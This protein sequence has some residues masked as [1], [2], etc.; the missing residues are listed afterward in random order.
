MQLADIVAARAKEHRN[1]GIILLP[2]G[3][4]EHVPEVSSIL[5]KSFQLLHC[6][7]DTTAKDTICKVQLHM[8]IYSLTNPSMLMFFTFCICTLAPSSRSW[9]SCRLTVYG[10]DGCHDDLMIKQTALV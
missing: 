8:F 2:E 5:S 1:Y 10:K 6:L 3:L 7:R 4:I 9:M